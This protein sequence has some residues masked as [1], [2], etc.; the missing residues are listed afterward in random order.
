M[1]LFFISWYQK[2][3]AVQRLGDVPISS[4]RTDIMNETSF[5]RRLIGSEQPRDHKKVMCKRFFSH[6]R[7]SRL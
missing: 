3:Q 5:W 7:Q 6:A 1:H 2:I 4:T